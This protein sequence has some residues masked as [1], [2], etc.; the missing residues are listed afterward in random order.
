M[1]RSCRAFSWGAAVCPPLIWSLAACAP[2]SV[3]PGAGTAAAAPAPP[4]GSEPAGLL[5]RVP[6]TPWPFYVA[7]DGQ[8]VEEDV[9]KAY[10]DE[11]WSQFY[12]ERYLAQEQTAERIAQAEREFS[13]DVPALFE[14]LVRGVMFLRE[15]Q[16]RYPELD[17]HEVE[18]FRH[19][20]QA[21]AGGAYMV[22]EKTLGPEGVRVHVLRQLRM[23][24]LEV[25]LAE[26]A[27]PITEEQVIA[28]YQRALSEIP[29]EEV[30]VQ[31]TFQEAA[32]FVRAYLEQNRR[33]DAGNAWVDAHRAG[34][35]TRVTRPNGTVVEF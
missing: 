18:S 5:W 20:M 7:V 10:L 6:D 12:T 22:L 11:P 3:A 32:P 26:S 19:S 2:Q 28:E 34:V 31:P 27:P 8:V 24:K 9:V 1:I 13:T 35:K 23:R 14:N 33:A 29:P 30:P 25:E 16:R 21:E 15:A 17:E 4:T